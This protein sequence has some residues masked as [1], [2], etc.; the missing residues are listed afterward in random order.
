MRAVLVVV[1]V[2]LLSLPVFAQIPKVV[3]HEVLAN[4]PGAFTSLEWV[5]LFNADSNPAW[6]AN[7]SIVVGSDTSHLDSC[8]VILPPSGFIVVSRRPVSETETENSFEKQWGNNSGIWGDDASENYPLLK[9]KFSL[10][11]GSGRILLLYLNTPV[12]SFIWTS[13]AGDGKSWERISTSYPATNSNLGSCRAASGS[14]PGKINSVAPVA[15]DLAVEQTAVQNLTGSTV[16]L[17]GIVK[18]VG[19][20]SV[21]PRYLLFSLGVSGDTG[22]T[23]TQAIDSSLVLTLAPQG[24]DSFSVDLTLPNGYQRV[25]ISLPPDGRTENNLAAV[26][27]RI[28][29][30]TPTLLINEFLPDPQNPLESEWIELY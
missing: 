5:E 8:S 20:D 2:V 13:D 27:F 26:N 10:S 7:F 25:V 23:I 30:L 16:R 28:G 29:T 17:S 3:L 9:G 22:F 19:L 11:N 12:D 14:T 6:L 4:E 1:F 15:N 21:A 24:I 18:N